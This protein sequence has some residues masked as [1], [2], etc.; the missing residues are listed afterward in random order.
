MKAR[1]SHIHPFQQLVWFLVFIT[2]G[3]LLATVITSVAAIAMFGA[4]ALSSTGALMSNPQFL[5]VAQIIQVF[6]LMFV[7]SITFFS[8]F[9]NDDDF[10]QFTSHSKGK[11]Y[12]MSTIAILIS[13]PLI[14]WS[15][16]ANSQ[17]MHLAPQSELISWMD[18]KEKELADLTYLFLNTT[19]MPVMLMN[20]IIMAVLPALFEEMFFRGVLQQKLTQWWG[21]GHLAIFVTAIVFSAIHMQFITF[22]PRFLLGLLLG[23][24]LRWGKTLWLP[25]LAHF[26]NNFV[27][28]LTFYYQKSQSPDINPVTA[29][30]GSSNGWIALISAA[31]IVM[32]LIKIRIESREETPK[33]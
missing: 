22:L 16:W 11:I 24:L 13:Q 21:K 6:G 5:R 1:L 8:L 9:G 30:T 10:A 14:G 2:A 31:T 28:V 19:Q 23:Y 4:D 27:A 33:L 32:L 17:L 26:I 7:P 18:G 12:I 25:I 29:E 20:V 3:L 15:A